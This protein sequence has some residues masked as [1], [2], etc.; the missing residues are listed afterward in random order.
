MDYFEALINLVVKNKTIIIGS[1]RFCEQ[2]V[3]VT[4]ETH[5]Y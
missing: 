3:T 2:Y 1:T 5:G 4:G